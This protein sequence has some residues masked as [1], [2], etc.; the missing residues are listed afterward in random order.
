MQ[1]LGGQT[2]SI[3]VFSEVA[4]NLKVAIIEHGELK[5]IVF[6]LVEGYHVKTISALAN[7]CHHSE[8]VH[9]EKY[10]WLLLAICQFNDPN[11]CRNHRS[12]LFIICFSWNT[13]ISSP[14]NNGSLPR[15]VMRA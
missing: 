3:M 7:L 11:R 2:K 9:P 15:N 4:Y 10:I 8:L 5:M 14:R 1:N 6:S 13:P 12:I